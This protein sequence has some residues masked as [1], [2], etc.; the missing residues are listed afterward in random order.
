MAKKDKPK[1]QDA[2]VVVDEKGLSSGSGE[3]ADGISLNNSDT[4]EIFTGTLSVTGAAGPYTFTLTGSGTGNFGTLVLNPIT[5]TY[6]YTLTSRFDGPDADNGANVTTGRDTFGVI[7]TA[8]NGETA[9]SNI[10]VSIIDDVPLASN[11][12]NSAPQGTTVQGSVLANDTFGADGPTIAGGGVVGV[13][14]GTGTTALVGGVGT[15]I[16][17]QY[18]TL[19]LNA[20]GTY[21]YQAQ[22]PVNGTAVE[23]FSYTIRDGDG[24]TSTARLAITVTGTGPAT[25]NV[26]DFGAKGDGVTN[27]QAAIQAAINAAFQ[28]GGGVVEVPGGVYMI[29]VG[30]PSEGDGP[31][32]LLSNVTLQGAGMGVTVLKLMDNVT[33]NINGFVRTPAD[34]VVQ[35]VQL[36]DLT[37]DGNRAANTFKANAFLCGVAPGNPLASEDITISGVEARNFTGYGFDP[38]ERT[39]RLTIEN[40]VAHHNGLDGFVADFQI[41]S[42][43]RN[44]ESYANDRHGF[45]IVTSTSGFPPVV[46]ASHECSPK[47]RRRSLP[48]R[49]QPRGP[50][51]RSSTGGRR[52]DDAAAKEYSPP[53]MILPGNRD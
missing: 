53:P 14:A 41:D 30:G 28:A 9:R 23:N 5:G 44:N 3:L 10:S 7:V 15:A 40:S 11:D 42:V 49:Q 16:A 48:P 19:T 24:D 32:E 51:H 50:Q 43:F 46:A 31:I 18:G 21:S 17:G 29:G 35:N 34:E 12:V 27:D 4:S 37:L 52:D 47:K 38:H 20:N 39:V 8:A 33:Q 13:A 36:L 26:R 25:F 6:T 1:P 45:N 2:T 22:N